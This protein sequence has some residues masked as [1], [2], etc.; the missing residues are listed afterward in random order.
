[1][2]VVCVVEKLVNASRSI[3]ES[4]WDSAEEYVSIGKEYP[5]YA[6]QKR[7]N[8]DWYLVCDNLCL[9]GVY[10][11]PL[12]VPSLYFKVLDSSVPASWIHTHDGY[13][14]DILVGEHSIYEDLTD[15][16]PEAINLFLRIKQEM[17]QGQSMDFDL[18]PWHDSELSEIRIDRSNP[19]LHDEV[20][21][22]VFWIDRQN[23]RRIVFK[24]VSRIQI[25]CNYGFICGEYGEPILCARRERRENGYVFRIETSSTG[26]VIEITAK[27]W[28]LI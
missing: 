12:Y 11:Y 1:M 19:G 16:K 6:I 20:V 18:L 23:M 28:E 24:D 21:F 7:E 26:S 14:P 22:S 9:Q 5:V 13:G 3:K 27:S 15:C 8:I 10:P 2:L 4:G 17:Y 25:D